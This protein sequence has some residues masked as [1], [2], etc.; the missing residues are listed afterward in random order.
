MTEWAQ[1]EGRPTVP[2][3]S[4][5]KRMQEQLNRVIVEIGREKTNVA[6]HGHCCAADWRFV[7]FYDEKFRARV[8][9]FAKGEVL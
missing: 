2:L 3:S 6:R 8:R 4:C 9:E 7:S 1:T 5:N